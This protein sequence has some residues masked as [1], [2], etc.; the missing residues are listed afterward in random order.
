M[1]TTLKRG[2]G[3][4]ADGTNGA[5]GHANGHAA[6]P[7]RIPPPPFSPMSRYGRHGRHP[8]RVVGSVFAWLLVILLV[9][10]GGLAGGLWLWGEQSLADT[11]PKT[12][13]E[14]E[15][16]KILDAVPPADQ[17][18][19][20]IVIGYDWR[21][22]E[23]KKEE[24]RSDTIMLIRA[25]PRAKTIS[26][27]SF[28][29][30]LLVEI[31]SC[32]G[33]PAYAAKINE[34]FTQG[35]TRCVI[36]TVRNL[37]G[38]PI[39]YYITVDFEGFN[40]I[41]NNLG[42]VYMDI[43]HRYFN[44][45][46]S[47]GELYSAIDLHPGYQKLGGATAL[48]YVRFRHTDNDFYRNARQ[49]EFVKAVKH[50][51]SGLSGVFA[52]PGI[53]DSIAK[54]VTVGSGGGKA[55]DINSVLSYARLAYELPSGNLFQ[56]RLENLTDNAYFQ[57][58]AADGE[59]ERVVSEFMNPDP[60]AGRKATT[61]AVGGK[62]EAGPTG[63][64]ASR[65]SVEVLNGNGVAGA[66]DDAAFRLQQRGYPAVNGGNADTL[67]YFKTRV[68]FDPSVQG[69][70]A[71]ATSLARLFGDA[72]TV[73]VGTGDAPLGSMLR[74]I[75]GTTFHGT[76]APAPRD[77]T[78]THQPA[79]VVS[80]PESIRPL[81]RQAQKKSDFKVLLPTVRETSSHLSTLEGMR[82]YRLAGHDAVR[83]AFNG[84]T[85]LDYWGIQETS[86]TEAP[87]L[88]GPTLTRQI[89]KREYKLYYNGPKL[90][91]VAFEENGAAY[92]VVNT[93]L[94]KLSNETML[95]I[96]KGLQPAGRS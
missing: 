50:Q 30:D 26:M 8:L 74:V 2:V 27:L 39:N 6:A 11:R 47:G 28:P 69:S 57:L 84:P 91:L 81:V 25:D 40:K 64:P 65:V 95:A 48:S 17:P 59:I 18:A 63:P 78:P 3:R 83:F 16:E 49:Q 62:P 9:T 44:D 15:A 51:I 43:D 76:L 41:V 29:R 79:A 46:S 45:N 10:L 35:G 42:G 1:R 87:I 14:K 90:H 88:E 36:E 31:P 80:D 93:L 33:K 96:A 19:V 72:E 53:V 54:S 32:D 22:K 24:S 94:D 21:K 73:P 7:P 75:V 5:N 52:L 61:V 86:W 56:P 67:D 60:R 71:A 58:S 55:L 37:T 77:A 20:A 82:A 4:A 13:E 38:V 68:V 89:G 85:E 92:W 12:Q 66:A 23:W 34:A 70:R